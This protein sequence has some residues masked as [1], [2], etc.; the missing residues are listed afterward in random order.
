VFGKL[1]DTE[2]SQK[3][4]RLRNDPDYEAS[5]I[6]QLKNNR[7]A[8]FPKYTNPE[9][10]YEDIVTPWRNLTTSILGEAADETQSWWQ[11]MVATNDFTTGSATLRTKGLEMG[12]NQVT[13]EATE[14]LQRALGDGSVL[15]NL[16]ANQ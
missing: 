2:L 15:Q 11:D 13:I 14:A 9:L 7:L 10:S 6:D 3:A 8:L 1:T 12:N 16:G 5:L 4:G